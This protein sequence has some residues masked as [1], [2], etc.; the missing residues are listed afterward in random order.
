MDSFLSE[1]NKLY[2]E[3]DEIYHIYAKE[4]GLSDSV[5][6]ILYSLAES[7]VSLTQ[8]DLCDL[9]HWT[10]QTVNSALKRLEGQGVIRLV[11]VSGSH[12]SKNI[13]LTDKGNDYIKRLIVPIYE[14]ESRAFQS[15]SPEE[16]SMLLTLTSKYVDLLKEEI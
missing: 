2:Q 3:L 15:M 10:A 5:L 1:F 16:R 9:W 11:P 7:D 14:A 4:H 12:K 13:V 8:K 6:W